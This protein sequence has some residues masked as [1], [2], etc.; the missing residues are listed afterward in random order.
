M[1]R[2]RN[3]RGN[4]TLPLLVPLLGGETWGKCCPSEPWCAGSSQPTAVLGAPWVL[5]ELQ[6][7]ARC[8]Q[9]TPTGPCSFLSLA[10]RWQPGDAAEAED[11]T[12]RGGME[13]KSDWDLNDFCLVRRVASVLKFP[14][15]FRVPN[16]T[17]FFFFG[18]SLGL[19]TGWQPGGLSNRKGN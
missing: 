15:G 19:G 2:K 5:L 3:K 12:P 10:R 4:G 9:S 13:G 11:W 1:K 6:L 14:P 7:T 17:S 16:E 18:F 8:P